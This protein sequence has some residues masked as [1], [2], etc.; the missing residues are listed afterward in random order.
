MDYMRPG[1]KKKEKK[2][3]MEIPKE[4]SLPEILY[5][6]PAINA[7]SIGHSQCLARRFAL[8]MLDHIFI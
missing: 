4:L 3:K 5:H 2:N 7:K 1:G 8:F 6:S